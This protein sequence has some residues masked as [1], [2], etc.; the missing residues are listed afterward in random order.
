MKTVLMVA[1]K[2]SL[3]QA[4]AK[5]LSNG[6]LVSRKGSNGACSVHEYNGKF[7]GE[8]VRFKMTSVCGHVMGLDF[9]GKYNN[10]DRVD[11]VRTTECPNFVITYVAVYIMIHYII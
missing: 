10:W 7:Q 11:P 9:V 8:T 5:I 2:P 6:N 4:L 3:A 1:E